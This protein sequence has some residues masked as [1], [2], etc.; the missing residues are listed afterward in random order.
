MK[1]Y[2]KKNIFIFVLILFSII[3]S[4]YVFAQEK[5]KIKVGYCSNKNFIYK[6]K[7]NNYTGYAVDCLNKIATYEDFEYEFIEASWDKSLEM[8][9]NKEIDLVFDSIY[10]KNIEEYFE[11]S[12]EA[13]GRAKIGLYT[14]KENNQIYYE[15][16]QTL[17]YKKIGYIKSSL[18]I[19]T[20]DDY[21]KYKEFDYDKTEKTDVA[22]AC[23][24]AVPVR[25]GGLRRESRG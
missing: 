16:F 11:Y 17:N 7:N 8:L 2:N 1:I 23:L 12:S 9:K 22:G 13:I 5:T 6:D 25:S 20:L 14:N 19:E 15:D 24:L 21:A 4:N 18:N 3:N 10:R